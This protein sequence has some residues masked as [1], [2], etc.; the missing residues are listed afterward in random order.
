[1]GQ[2]R[3]VQIS[4]IKKKLGV[5]PQKIYFFLIDLDVEGFLFLQFGHGH[6]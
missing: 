1:M 5:N 2:N 4:H 3:Q 6:S